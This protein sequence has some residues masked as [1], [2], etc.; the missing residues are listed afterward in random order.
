MAGNKTI[1]IFLV[2]VGYTV[3]ARSF[4]TL[5]FYNQQTLHTKLKLYCI[6]K[7]TNCNK[8]AFPME[9]CGGF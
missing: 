9:I 5:P 1:M 2:K 4:R 7:S 6:F 3:P 8:F